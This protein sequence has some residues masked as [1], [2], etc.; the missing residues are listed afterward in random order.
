MVTNNSKTS[1]VLIIDDS[2][3]A[4]TVLVVLLESA[5]YDVISVYDGR[6]ALATLRTHAFDLAILDN[7]MPNLGGIE[8]LT[9][10]RDFLPNMP[11]IVCSGAVTERES[12][13][14]RELGIA[15]LVRKPVETRT[16]LAKVSEALS[17]RDPR[18]AETATTLLPTRYTTTPFA[19]ATTIP[20]FAGTSMLA[21]K[22]QEDFQ[23][24]RAFRS[25]AILEGPVGSGRFELALALA[26]TSNVHTIVCHADELTMDHLNT[27][28]ASAVLDGHPVFLIVLDAER[29]PAMRQSILEN[30]VRGRF[31]QHATVSKTLRLVLCARTSLC[32]NLFDEFLLMRAVAS[33]RTLPSFAERRQDWAEIARTVLRRLGTG[34]GTFDSAAVAWIENYTWP[35]N[36]MQ[37]HR[38]VE[39]ARRNAGVSSVISMRHLEESLAAERT[40]EEPLFHDVLY[41]VHSGHD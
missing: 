9:E 15:D 34:R 38:T 30:L 35:G 40:C 18:A 37:L 28:L 19:A 26:P 5:G 24:L 2:H 33:T 12:T 21:N 8:T 36:Y 16:L 3:E 23:R 25:V 1:R 32:D 29:L 27:L 31:E 4:V 7:D 14:Y 11:V 39:L 6:E 41:H 20:L 13:R 10:L 17:N 22:L